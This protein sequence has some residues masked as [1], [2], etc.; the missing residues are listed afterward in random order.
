MKSIYETKS[1]KLILSYYTNTKLYK[2][3]VFSKSITFNVVELNGKKRDYYVTVMLDYDSVN[4]TIKTCYIFQSH[5]SLG[6]REIV[7][8]LKCDGVFIAN[9]YNL[10][11]DDINNNNY[12]SM[13]LS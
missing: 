13:K 8:K 11:F 1:Y 4:K 9:I 6:N 2:N 3:N 12:I 7:K 5:I 10:L